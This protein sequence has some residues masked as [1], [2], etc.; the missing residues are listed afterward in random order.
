VISAGRND[1]LIKSWDRTTLKAVASV[2]AHEG[3]VEDLALAPDG[4]SLAT[5]GG[6]G[7]VSLWN[8]ANL[9]LIKSL[10]VNRAAVHGLA[11]SANGRWLATVDA[12]AGGRVNV[13]DVKSAKPRDGFQ[14]IAHGDEAH[15]IAF[16]AGDRMLVSADNLGS[17]RLA[18]ATTGNSLAALYGHTG[19]IW[20]ISVSPDGTTFATVGSN[21]LV[22][23]WDARLPTHLVGIHVDNASGALA[24]TPDGRTLIIA[25]VVGGKGLALPSGVYCS[26]D[27]SLEVRGFDPTNGA[28]QF[29]RVLARGQRVLPIVCLS[30]DAA[31]ACF[32]QPDGA[33]TVWQVSNGKRL[34]VIQNVAHVGLI[35]SGSV[36]VH[37]P[38]SAPMELVDVYNGQ[39]RTLPGTESSQWEGLAQQAEV[40][41]VRDGDFTTIWDL[42]G[43]PVRRARAPMKS[44]WT[45]FALS[46]DATIL[47]A[48]ATGPRG[49]I[50]LW[51]TTTLELIDSL[52]GHANNVSELDFTPDGKVLAS[53]DTG[54]AL[55]LWDLATRVELPT[56]P[57]PVAASPTLRFS[58]DGRALAFRSAAWNKNWVY[59]LSTDLPEG[60]E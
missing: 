49:T 22:K 14:S 36:L 57:L 50:E 48:G 11:F 1:C 13:W 25:D 34:A 24:F 46:P 5:A 59:V 19:K 12:W 58:H 6:D 7:Y 35:R 21:G 9:T 52:P 29:H 31:L 8:L 42:S 39:R 16:L 33:T 53:L 43:F 54:G 15:G 3:T 2:R 17:V 20:G 10:R 27:A 18:D 4:T 40:L 38:S 28:E 44:A 47:A 23:L 41:A 45:V 55:K 56:P 60:V 37:P 26:D 51:D 30:A 32:V